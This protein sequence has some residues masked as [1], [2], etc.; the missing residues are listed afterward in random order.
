MK[1]WHSLWLRVIGISPFACC[2]T[3]TS[4]SLATAWHHVWK[5][6]TIWVVQP[7]GLAGSTDF[8]Q[9]IRTQSIGSQMWLGA[10][11]L[12]L[13]IS[14]GKDEGLVDPIWSPVVT[15]TLTS[16]QS[17]LVAWVRASLFPGFQH[18]STPRPKKTHYPPIEKTHPKWPGRSWGIPWGSQT[19]SRAPELWLPSWDRN[20]SCISV[21]MADDGEFLSHRSP[22]K[23]WLFQY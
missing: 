4:P 10:L 8:H 23:P 2:F 6:K 20:G 18:V 9:D 15:L 7:E 19:S 22:T 14:F 16:L 21:P 3:H 13:C 5:V 1:L 17:S 11:N 12:G